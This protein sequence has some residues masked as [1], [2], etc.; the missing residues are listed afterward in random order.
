VL[1]LFM[2]PPPPPFTAAAS[3]AQLSPS[4]YDKACPGRYE[5]VR[6]VLKP[7]S[8]IDPRLPASLIRLHFHD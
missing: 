6:G 7:A 3:A 8:E 5:T 4:F 1:L 2:V